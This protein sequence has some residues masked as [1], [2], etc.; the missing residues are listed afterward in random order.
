MIEY[1]DSIDLA[2]TGKSFVKKD[3]FFNL[4]KKNKINLKKYHIIGIDDKL[5]IL[6]IIKLLKEQGLN[7][8]GFW[9]NRENYPKYDIKYY[10]YEI[11]SLKEIIKFIIRKK[12]KKPL[13][14]SD[15]DNTL[16]RANYEITKR[17][18][19]ETTIW[20]KMPI[21]FLSAA[22]AIVIAPF[23]YITILID[24]F[25]NSNTPYRESKEFKN[26]LI[27][28]N[29]KTWIISYRAKY[30]QKKYF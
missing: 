9:I 10:D 29:I 12:I 6:K 20:D 15:F 5:G 17:S 23:T 19:K 13:I 7:A 22:L 26:Y 8:T 2:I 27:R 11:F 21:N 1:F 25:R 16:A 3:L 30:L 24:L 18:A 14:I 28:K 4:I